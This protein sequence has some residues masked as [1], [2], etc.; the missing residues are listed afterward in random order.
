MR[1][2][3]DKWERNNKHRVVNKYV[4]QRR[5]SHKF[6]QRMIHGSDRAAER[7]EVR[8][9]LRDPTEDCDS[10]NFR[11]YTRA[12]NWCWDRNMALPVISRKRDSITGRSLKWNDEDL[13][14]DDFIKPE[15]VKMLNS[16]FQHGVKKWLRHRDDTLKYRRDNWYIAPPDPLQDL[17][18]DDWIDIIAE[19]VREKG[20]NYVNDIVSLSVPRD[21]E[22]FWQQLYILQDGEYVSASMLLKPLKNID[23]ID[24]WIDRIYKTSGQM[25][26]TRVRGKNWELH[27]RRSYYG[28]AYTGLSN[29]LK[30]MIIAHLQNVDY[31]QAGRKSRFSHY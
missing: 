17:N 18:R 27:V 1:S 29:K 19:I 26:Y 3:H 6:I 12:D 5:G 15:E 9:A 4:I 23:D 14:D 7:M 28:Y 22:V 21:S 16:F 30:V 10:A 31:Y 8:R 13:E 11:D 25:L 2:N 20:L 24:N